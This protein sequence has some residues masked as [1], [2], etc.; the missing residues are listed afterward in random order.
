MIISFHDLA[1]RWKPA[2]GNHE[3]RYFTKVLRSRQWLL[4]TGEQIQTEG[5]DIDCPKAATSCDLISQEI[6]RRFHL[7]KRRVIITRCLKTVDDVQVEATSISPDS[8]NEIAATRGKQIAQ[9]RTGGCGD[10]WMVLRNSALRKTAGHD[11]SLTAELL[12]R[13][14][15]GHHVPS[16]AASREKDERS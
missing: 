15:K 14:R 2:P 4:V 1:L 6:G 13:T 11:A 5:E 9:E 7:K 8:G 12:A 3:G 10:E 16:T